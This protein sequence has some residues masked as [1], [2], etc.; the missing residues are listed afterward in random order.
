MRW[1]NSNEH[2]NFLLAMLA[3]QKQILLSDY[4][5]TGQRVTLTQVKRW[6]RDEGARSS[7]IGHEADL[8]LPL[9]LLQAHLNTPVSV[10]TAAAQH[11]DESPDQPEP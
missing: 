2:S 4:Q 3:L 7:L 8:S 5:L 9:F 1:P 6:W 11:D 10:R